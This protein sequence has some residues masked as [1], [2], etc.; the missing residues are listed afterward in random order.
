M[1]KRKIFIFWVGEKSGIEKLIIKLKNMKFDVQIGPSNDEHKFLYKNY[2]YYRVAYDNKIW[3]FCSDVWRV[4]KLSNEKGLYIDTSVEI[5]KDFI[6]FYDRH[7]SKEVT[8]F[9]ETS[10][11]IAS[12]ILFSGVLN[13][14]FYKKLLDNFDPKITFDLRLCPLLPDIISALLCK[15]INFYGFSEVRLGE[16][17]ILSLM[18]I[19]NK[20]EIFKVGTASWTEKNKVV[21]M[22]KLVDN[23]FWYRSEQAWLNNKPYD[24]YKRKL[25]TYMNEDK[26]YINPT[27]FKIRIQYDKSSTYEERKALTEQYKKINYRTRFFDKLIWSKLFVFFGGNKNKA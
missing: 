14:N 18:R 2:S 1:K 25:H 8:V 15:K 20:E 24:F 4:Y 23:N 11:S 5:G 22:S 13:N 12:S 10:S 3:S 6:K 7:I 27:P 26:Q 17:D 21:S 16:I 19:R 9:K